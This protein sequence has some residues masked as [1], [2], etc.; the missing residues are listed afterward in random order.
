LSFTSNHPELL[1]KA[2][3]GFVKDIGAA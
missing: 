1:A 2:Q 3:H